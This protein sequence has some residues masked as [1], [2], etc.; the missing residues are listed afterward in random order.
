MRKCLIQE[1]WAL[2]DTQRERVVVV[3]V[4]SPRLKKIEKE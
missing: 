3:I 1:S 4:M 2:P